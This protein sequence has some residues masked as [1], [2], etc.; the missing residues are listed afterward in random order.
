MGN[1]IVDGCTAEIQNNLSLVVDNLVSSRMISLTRALKQSSEPGPLRGVAL[2]VPRPPCAKVLPFPRPGEL[3]VWTAT[4]SM[5][6]ST[7][8]GCFAR[9]HMPENKG[10]REE[11]RALRH[12]HNVEVD[13]L[14]RRLAYLE[15]Q[16]HEQ[17]VRDSGKAGE[18]L[19]GETAYNGNRPTMPPRLGD[20]H[21]HFPDDDIP[22]S[23]FD[24]RSLSPQ[25]LLSQD[26]SRMAMASREGFL[27]SKRGM[28]TIW[29]KTARCPGLKRK[30]SLIS[31][32][33]VK[34]STQY[35]S[36]TG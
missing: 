22:S 19:G 36:A 2:I 34:S 3:L 25:T 16:S 5:D 35:P 29:T 31:L 15:S 4:W 33:F 10:H 14:R 27:P 9:K 23:S 7:R 17:V 20:K 32:T 1:G 8:S 24:V 13:S 18:V 28:A 12:L 11:M 21:Y 30:G 6:C 26:H